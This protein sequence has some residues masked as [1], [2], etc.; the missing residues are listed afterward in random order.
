MMQVICANCGKSLGEQMGPDELTSHG[1]CSVC[2]VRLYP[3]LYRWCPDCGGKGHDLNCYGRDATC[4]R[5]EGRRYVRR[6]PLAV[7]LAPDLR[8]DEMPRKL[9]CRALSV[10]LPDWMRRHE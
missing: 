10:E 1:L 8:E 9:T 3:D 2:M 4:S 6:T 7:E 5:C